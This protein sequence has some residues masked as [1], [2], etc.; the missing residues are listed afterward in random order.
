VYDA[1]QVIAT[2]QALPHNNT[3]RGFT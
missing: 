1:A 3:D 2:G